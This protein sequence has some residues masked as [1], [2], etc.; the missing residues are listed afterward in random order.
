MQSQFRRIASRAE[1]RAVIRFR[2]AGLDAMSPCDYQV[3]CHRFARLRR[4]RT[5]AATEPLSA[6][7]QWNFGSL[8]IGTRSRSW[9]TGATLVAAAERRP[10]DFADSSL[11]RRL[12]QSRVQLEHF[13][14]RV[15]CEPA[16]WESSQST[17][18]R[19]GALQ[20][21]W[22]RPLSTYG[23]QPEPIAP[24]DKAAIP[25]PASPSPSQPRRCRPSM[26]QRPFAT[27]LT[28]HEPSPVDTS[29]THVPT[30][31]TRQGNTFAIKKRRRATGGT[32]ECPGPLQP[33]YF[34]AAA[35]LSPTSPDRVHVLA[36]RPLRFPLATR[37]SV[38]FKAR[39]IT[40]RA[41][42]QSINFSSLP[43]SSEN[44]YSPWM[45]GCEVQALP[46]RSIHTFCVAQPTSI[47]CTMS[48]PPHLSPWEHPQIPSS[49]SVL[50]RTQLTRDRIPPT[51]R[52]HH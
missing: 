33:A 1:M 29:P 21:K 2:A 28:D 22:T 14:A 20:S 9:Q 30:G 5:A 46:S 50:L 24:R 48:G 51:F 8:D 11:A 31:R 7:I 23:G 44:G 43:L 42:F 52:I 6:R 18:P 16:G 19:N 17:V 15:S 45:T 41:T 27:R 32:L 34:H 39:R 35:P 26:L 10:R 37:D 36:P 4:S 3:S 40:G 38:P 47:F 13:L 12:P 25:G 49:R